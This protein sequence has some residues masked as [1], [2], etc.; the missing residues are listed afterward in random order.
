MS[1]IDRTRP[2]IQRSLPPRI[3]MA[4]TLGG[5][6]EDIWL[7]WGV[8]QRNIN[9]RVRATPAE[10]KIIGSLPLAP[11]MLSATPGPR[12]SLFESGFE[13]YRAVERSE[14][15]KWA[16][17]QAARYI[18]TITIPGALIVRGQSSATGLLAA[19][20]QWLAAS[21]AL[22][23]FRTASL[24]IE[25]LIR[26]IL[27]VGNNR[28]SM[29]DVDLG[30]LLFYRGVLGALAPAAVTLAQ[31]KGIPSNPTALTTPP[32]LNPEA[33]WVPLVVPN[34]A[35]AATLIMSKNSKNLGLMRQDVDQ[36]YESAKDHARL[37]VNSY[38]AR[39]QEAGT[40][41]LGAEKARSLILAEGV[42]PT[43]TLAAVGGVALAGFAIYKLWNR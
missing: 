40:R 26:Y 3:R 21:Q 6:A 31:E 27:D 5:S 25:Q 4:R 14:T 42:S 22:D 10:A 24:T 13:N 23:D 34:D 33:L 11:M 35:G 39:L 9:S 38:D 8:D 17:D 28:D 41:L 37:M 32:G 43:M 15:P 12:P 19:P 16:I 29:V 30:S 2:I 1:S 36:M 7:R 20:T 18:P